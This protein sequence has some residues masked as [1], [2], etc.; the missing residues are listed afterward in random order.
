MSTVAEIENA[1]QQLSA[2]EWRELRKRLRLSSNG[3][4]AASSGHPRAS[5]LHKLSRLRSSVSTGVTD[6]STE[7][8]LSD[9]RSGRE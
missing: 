7:N 8:I 3:H 2:E 6:A 4:S 1:I 9:L 5:W